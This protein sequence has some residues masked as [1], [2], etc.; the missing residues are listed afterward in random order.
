MATKLEELLP[1][2]GDY[3]KKL[4]LAQAEEA[5]ALLESD[6]TFGKVILDCR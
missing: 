6:T 2:A 5:Y 4:A 3:M 1:S